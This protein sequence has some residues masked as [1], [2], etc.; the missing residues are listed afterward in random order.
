MREV[1]IARKPDK[2]TSKDS[3]N[4]SCPSC[5]TPVLLYKVHTKV[6]NYRCYNCSCLFSQMG[7][8]TKGKDVK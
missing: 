3:V 4:F 8:I 1:Y 6:E 2:K 5:E 7:M